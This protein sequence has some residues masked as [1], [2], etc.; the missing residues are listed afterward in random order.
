MLRV[1]GEEFFQMVA[2]P[3]ELLLTL[4]QRQRPG[5]ADQGHAEL[6]VER[7]ADL[8]GGFGVVAQRFQQV[9]RNVVEV[10]LAKAVEEGLG[11][12]AGNYRRAAQTKATDDEDPGQE[13]R[14]HIRA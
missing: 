14:R 8:L 13:P 10:P 4:G 2:G 1:I 9:Q 12:V 7:F 6:I 3:V 5:A 11:V